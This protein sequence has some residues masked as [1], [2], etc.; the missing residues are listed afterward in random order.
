MQYEAMISVPKAQSFDDKPVTASKGNGTE[1]KY[2]L[3]LAYRED[4]GKTEKDM[5]ETRI[6]AQ[7]LIAQLE[8]PVEQSLLTRRYIMAEEW[9][10]VAADIGYTLRQTFRI[11][12]RALQKMSLN[13]TNIP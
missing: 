9:E 12:G 6:S 4:V 7:R 11:H 2:I 3:A 8:D 13:V 10:Q 1:D 5:L